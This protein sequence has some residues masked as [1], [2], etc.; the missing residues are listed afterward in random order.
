MQKAREG[1]ESHAIPRNHGNGS[2]FPGGRRRPGRSGQCA[3]VG[4]LLRPETREVR[5][6]RLRP[7]ARQHVRLHRGKAV[8]EKKITAAEAAKKFTKS[9]TNVITTSTDRCRDRRRRTPSS[10]TRVS[11]WTAWPEHLKKVLSRIPSGYK[12]YDGSKTYCCAR[13]TVVRSRHRVTHG[14]PGHPRVTG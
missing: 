8:H 6:L 3:E 5:R 14:S 12:M 11:S 10:A 4:Q 9:Y 7:Q 1:R 13:Q 2:R